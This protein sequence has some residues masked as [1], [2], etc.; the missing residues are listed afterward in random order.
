MRVCCWAPA[1]SLTT[2]LS[3]VI[4]KEIASP[5]GKAVERA[6][7]PIRYRAVGK[8]N[9]ACSPNHREEVFSATQFPAYPFLGTSAGMKRARALAP[10]LE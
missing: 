1:K 4:V 2:S 6:R 5:L 10:A 8:R 3:A 7:I 9:F